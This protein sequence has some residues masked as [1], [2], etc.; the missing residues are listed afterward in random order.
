MGNRSRI[1][2]FQLFP[3]RAW[4]LILVCGMAA[5]MTDYAVIDLE[6]VRRGWILLD[7]AGKTY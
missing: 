2:V 3:A 5:A 1:G 4:P 6:Y 7:A